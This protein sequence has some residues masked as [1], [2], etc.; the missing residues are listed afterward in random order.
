MGFRAESDGHMQ[1]RITYRWP[2]YPGPD[3]LRWVCILEEDLL[4]VRARVL[5]LGMGGDAGL[6]CRKNVVVAYRCHRLGNVK[7][8]RLEGSRLHYTART[9]ASRDDIARENVCCSCRRRPSARGT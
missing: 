2:E 7:S 5:W 8:M 6:N 3:G 4:R 1:S 9:L